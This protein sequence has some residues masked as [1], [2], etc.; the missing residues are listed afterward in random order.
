MYALLTR[1][2][3]TKNHNLLTSMVRMKKE[4]EDKS[5]YVPVCNLMSTVA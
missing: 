5:P 4:A 1:R 2:H 3:V